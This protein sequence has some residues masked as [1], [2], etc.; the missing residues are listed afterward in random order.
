MCYM[1]LDRRTILRRDAYLKKILAVLGDTYTKTDRHL[2]LP[3]VQEPLDDLAAPPHLGPP[4][5]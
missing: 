2:P 3:L 5:A 1:H 4:P